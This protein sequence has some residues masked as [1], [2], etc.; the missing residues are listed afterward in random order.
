MLK[1][2]GGYNWN[3]P[4]LCFL[5]ALPTASGVSVA[6]VLRVKG[7]FRVS[8]V[9]ARDIS[10]LGQTSPDKPIGAIPNGTL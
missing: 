6:T 9:L 1:S 5:Q 10:L 4:L 3:Q 2:F 8:A 7:K